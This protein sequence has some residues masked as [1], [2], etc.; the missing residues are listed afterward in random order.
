MDFHTHNSNDQIDGLVQDCSS[1]NTLA[2]EIL[3]SCTKPSK[4][5]VYRACIA[6]RPFVGSSILVPSR[7]WSRFLRYNADNLNITL[8]LW[9]KLDENVSWVNTFTS[10]SSISL[11][12][13]R[14]NIAYRVTTVSKLATAPMLSTHTVLSRGNG[15]HKRAT[16][17]SC[18]VSASFEETFDFNRVK[19]CSWR[20]FV[21][22][23][24]CFHFEYIGPTQLFSSCSKNS[25]FVADEHSTEN[26]RSG[27]HYHYHLQGQF[28]D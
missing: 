28:Q 13:T 25:I 8:K 3:Q 9:G 26:V 24:I 4:W 17:V 7:P 5:R 15:C 1:S 12:F 10:H 18:E 22:I 14:Q 19:Q 2:V 11:H 23:V 16:T 20:S 21:S 6:G 27:F